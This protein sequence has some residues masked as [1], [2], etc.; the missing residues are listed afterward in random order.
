MARF[1]DLKGQHLERKTSGSGLKIFKKLVPALR[2]GWN[3]EAQ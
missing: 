2:F 1:L 3:L